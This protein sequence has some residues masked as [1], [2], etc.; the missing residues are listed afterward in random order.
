MKKFGKRLADIWYALTDSRFY[1]YYLAALVFAGIIFLTMRCTAE[2]SNINNTYGQFVSAS[3]MKTQK[4]KKTADVSKDLKK[5]FSDYFKY[6]ADGDVDS[7]KKIAHPMSDREA[8]YIRFF[9]QYVMEYKNTKIYYKQGLNK[10][11]YLV[12][13]TEDVRFK[14]IDTAAPGLEFFYVKTDSKGKLYIDNAYSSFNSVNHISD[15]DPD[16]TALIAKYEQQDDFVKLRKD[17]QS[18]FN[19]ALLSDSKLSVFLNSTLS[20]ATTKWNQ[21]YDRQEKDEKET[22]EK[23]VSEATEMYTTE[24]V[25]V[26]DKASSDGT[27][28]GT[29]KK[30]E[31]VKKISDENGWSK[32]D[33]KDKT[34][35]VKTDKLSSDK[36]KSDSDKKS[37]NK[38]DKKNEKKSENKENKDNS[39]GNDK[40][41]ENKDNDNSSNTNNAGNGDN[42][43]S[44]STSTQQP[45]D[46]IEVAGLNPGAQIIL[47]NTVRVRT[48]MREDASIAAVAYVSEPVTI[49]ANYASGWTSITTYGGATGYVKTELLQ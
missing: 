12:S 30:G 7:I 43:Q 38:T 41:V 45:T 44:G 22:H 10:T 6:Y 3:D 49:G 28:L 29:L 32:I 15:M 34:G 9:S 5:L 11:S 20:D 36:P 19:Q 46:Q 35:Y 25:K 17:V 14:D 16:I 2:E 27:V 4:D 13:I 23:E 8:D 42:S 24:S 40:K 47:K 1:R 31:S 18:R 39:S 33:Y 26:M 21:D 37:E 48:D